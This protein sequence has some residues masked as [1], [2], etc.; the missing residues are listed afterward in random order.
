VAFTVA[1]NSG[2]ERT[3]T[4]T[5]GSQTFTVTQQG[6]C[7][8]SISP[9]SRTVPAAGGASTPPIAV[10]TAGGCEWTAVRNDPW[11]TITAGATGSGNGSVEFSVAA[12]AGPQRTGTL[13]IGGQTF[14]V[15]Q[16]SGCGVSISP[17]SRTVSAAGGASTPAIAVT[18]PGGCDWTAVRNDPWLTITAGATGS[19]NGSVEF[20]VAANAGPQRTGTLTIGGVTFTVTQQSGCSV[21][22]NPTSRTV[23]AGGGASTPPIAV[24]APAGCVWT[25]TANDGWL[26]ITAGATGSGNGSVEF[27]AAAN[28]GPQRNGTLTI[29]GQTFTVTQQNGCSVS[30]TPTSRTVAAAGGASTP[31]I[32][33]TAAAGCN[34]TAVSNV[35]WLSITAG[36]SGAGNG[37]VSF[38]AV[39]NVTPERVGTLTIG[40]Q[41][42]TVTQS[43]GCSYSL[44]RT[45]IQ[46]DFHSHDNERIRVTA[47]AGCTWTAVS[48]VSWLIIRVGATG[49]GNGDVRYDVLQNNGGPRTGRIIVAGI[50]FTVNQNER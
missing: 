25:A 50:T 48:Q 27:S 30:I 44:D 33:V 36:A 43:S 15:T 45:T 46:F 24:T 2:P 22:I 6:G 1:A 47:G 13:T 38:S 5:I 21:S 12:N 7:S 11:L 14:T 37:S 26:S 3:G 4:L 39:A 18:A 49:S 8:V 28:T 35:S 16:Q 10:S 32:A 20:S 29:G 9:T 23:P 42:F 17:T 31:P 19:G 34:W 40:G 41:T